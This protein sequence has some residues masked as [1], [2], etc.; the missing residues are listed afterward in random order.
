MKPDERAMMEI[1]VAT[2]AYRDGAG[3]VVELTKR[4]SY[5]LSKWVARG[6]WDC[7]VSLRSG[8]VTDRAAMERCLT[9]NACEPRAS[10]AAPSPG[11]AQSAARKR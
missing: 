6:W 7:G 4:Q 1:A 3:D 11:P 2:G 10:Q 9:S 8:W 5:I